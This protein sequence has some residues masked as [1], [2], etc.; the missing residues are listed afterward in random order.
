MQTEDFLTYSKP[1]LIGQVADTSSRQIDSYAAEGEIEFGD[2][3]IRGTDKSSQVKKSNSKTEFLGVA[4][5][6]DTLSAGLYREKV[7]VSVM[8][9]GRIVVKVKE[10]AEAGSDAY[11]YA[12]ATI[13]V[14]KTDGLKIGTFFNSAAKDSLIILEIR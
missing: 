6:N 13:G 5:R 8:T 4:V 12:D 7:M 10:D 14:T 9:R 2:P 1:Y 11:V 3:V